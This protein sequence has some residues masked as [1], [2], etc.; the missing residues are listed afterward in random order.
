MIHNISEFSIAHFITLHNKPSYVL[1]DIHVNRIARANSS[2]NEKQSLSSY[3]RSSLV[4]SK[5]DVAYARGE[6]L[7][8]WSWLTTHSIWSVPLFSSVWSTN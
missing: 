6:R 2:R 3:F 5:P 7:T 8:G 4:A 1:E